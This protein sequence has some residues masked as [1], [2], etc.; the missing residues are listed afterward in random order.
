LQIVAEGQEFLLRAGDTIEIPAG[1]VHNA[2]V[3]GEEEVVSLDATRLRPKGSPQKKRGAGRRAGPPIRLL[4]LRRVDPP[5]SQ[6]LW[7]ASPPTATLA[8][9]TDGL[10]RAS[11][12]SRRQRP[13][14][15][16]APNKSPVAYHRLLRM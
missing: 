9:G 6:R 14:R 7:R 8:C 11:P 16:K 1:T 2:K 10:W 15:K 4:G 3:I 13:A 12:K 5:T